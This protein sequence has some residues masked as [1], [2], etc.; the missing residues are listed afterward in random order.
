MC[1]VAK[2]KVPQGKRLYWKFPFQKYMLLAGIYSLNLRK[3]GLKL[4]YDLICRH[5]DQKFNLE[6]RPWR[7]NPLK[8]TSDRILCLDVR[9]SAG[10]LTVRKRFI[11]FYSFAYLACWWFLVM[12]GLLDLSLF[13]VNRKNSYKI[14]RNLGVN[15]P[16]FFLI[17]AFKGPTTGYLWQ[18]PGTKILCA[19][20]LLSATGT[21]I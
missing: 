12:N 4:V 9:R 16:H 7:R 17:A 2:V 1:P 21:L 18:V 5:I 19:F 13:C 3:E 10:S 8:N 20:S 6:I 14:G 11:S 15:E